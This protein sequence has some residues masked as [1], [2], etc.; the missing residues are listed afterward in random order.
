MTT[1]EKEYGELIYSGPPNNP[2]L[3]RKHPRMSLENSAKIFSPFAALRGHGDRIL[4]END[5][6]LREVRHQLSEEDA[7]VLSDKLLQVQKGMEITVVYFVPDITD[8]DL[9]N[10]EELTGKVMQIDPVYRHIK[11]TGNIEGNKQVDTVVKFDD[12]LNVRGEGIVD[13]DT[14]LEID[15]DWSDVFTVE[16]LRKQDAMLDELGKDTLGRL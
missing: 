2:D 3:Y 16:D 13:I 6:L 9:G 1:A 5:N 15:T 11:I 14:Y 12:L 7:E 4:G 10:Y 8:P